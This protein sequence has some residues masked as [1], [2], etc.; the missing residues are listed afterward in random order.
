MKYIRPTTVEDHADGTSSIVTN[1]DA[2]AILNKNKELLNNYGDKLTFG[3]Q[4][5]GMTVASIPARKW[6]E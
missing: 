2:E 4:T 3:K 6:E 5:S 1:Q